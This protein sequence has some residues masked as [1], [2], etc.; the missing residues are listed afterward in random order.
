M[1]VVSDTV[2]QPPELFVAALAAELS[3]T[4]SGVGFIYDALERLVA[5]YDLAD[6]ILVIHGPATGRQA[7][8]AGRRPIRGGWATERA[9]HAPPGLHT[10]PVILHPDTAE[11]L[12][13]LCSV[14]LRLDLL[15]HDAT[16]DPLT[17]LLNRRSFDDLLG[18]SV[19]RS[20]RY[21]WE[22]TLVL[23]DLNRFK[24]LND[25]LGHPAGD[26]VLRAVGRGLR[27][28][29]RAGDVAAR[30]GGDEFAVILDGTDPDLG[31]GLAARLSA[32]AGSMLGWAEVGFSVG[33]ASAPS[34]GTDAAALLD[35]ADHRLYAAKAR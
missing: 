7:F 3:R 20:A 31:R 32:A 9:L 34:E 2:R 28:F 29:L 24:A 27:S 25:R 4:T 26:E 18:R 5:D 15:S 16:H 23:M 8:R 17:G 6:A 22:F 10:D 12:A 21:G 14:A 13:H 1:G 35:V 30:I 19:S 33:T 11:S